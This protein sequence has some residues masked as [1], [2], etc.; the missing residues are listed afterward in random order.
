MAL[1]GKMVRRDQAW[2]A[3]WGRAQ[4]LAVDGMLG[5]RVRMGSR[6]TPRF[7]ARVTGYTWFYLL[8]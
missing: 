1:A 3:F 4:S 7:L 6:M 2:D 5:V 8:R